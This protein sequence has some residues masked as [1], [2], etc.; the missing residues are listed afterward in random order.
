VE[1]IFCDGRESNC[2]RKARQQNFAVALRRNGAW[3]NTRKELRAEKSFQKAAGGV[4]N[5]SQKEIPPRRQNPAGRKLDRHFLAR[6]TR[7]GI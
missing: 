7:S 3:F 1:S 6:R 2:A 4:S 5:L